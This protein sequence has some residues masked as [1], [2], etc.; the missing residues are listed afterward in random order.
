MFIGPY[1][2]S[3]NV[4]VAPMAG[5][6]DRP[7]RQLVKRL[8]AGY[9]VSEMAASN[10]K[11][12]ATV[13]SS[14]R[15]NHDGEIEPKSIQIAGADPTMMAEAAKYNV[16]KG[17]QIIDIN[18]GCPAKK[19]CN[20]AAG[21]ALMSQPALAL[22]IVEAVV[23]AVNVP[24]T[25]KMRT[26]P[27]RSAT[28]APLL[29]KQFEQ[30]GIQMLAIHGRSRACAYNGYAEYDTIAQIKRD[31]NI[32]IVANGDIDSCEKALAVLKQTQADAV[33]I[34]RAAQGNPW[35]PGQ[36][37]Y[38]LATGKHLADPTLEAQWAVIK[39]HLLDHYNFHG[40]L[41][42]ARTARKHIGWYSQQWLQGQV[43]RDAFNQ[44]EN[45][46]QQLQALDQYFDTLLSGSTILSSNSLT[47]TSLSSTSFSDTAT[48][49]TQHHKNNTNWK[50]A[51]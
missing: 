19:V 18:L 24:V 39:S 2:L 13:K 40:A 16:D 25:L 3:N 37:A 34:G 20:L 30:A 26:G 35:L 31:A 9:A 43:L 51:A 21:S 14:Q 46:E 1:Q 47:S 33:M 44:T 38:Y 45:P 32:P 4:F 36:I 6:T 22:Q 27:T 12:W 5:V 29:A 28:N 15:L 8:G 50:Q 49:Q 23:A 42:G 7:F 10:P 17:A 11:L 41:V 48:N